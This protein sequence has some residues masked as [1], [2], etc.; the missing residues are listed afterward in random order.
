M[1][2][3]Y[4]ILTVL[5]FAIYP[6]V[7]A[8][9][10][11][12]LSHFPT[13]NELAKW[14]EIDFDF[15]PT[16][17]PVAPI[18]NIAEFERTEAVLVRYP[19]GIPLSLIKEM[20]SDCVV[21]TLVANTSQETTVRTQYQSEGI[22]LTN[23]Q[24]ILAASDSY[25]TRDYGP[26][27][28][29]DGNN[30]V[31]IV[32][33]TY[34]RPR[35]NDNEVPVFVADH[36]DVSYY[37]MDLSATGGNWMCDGFGNGVS[38]D[39]IWE[40]NPTM[41]HEDIDNIMQEYLGIDQFH[42]VDDPLGDYIK[43][44]DCWGK[45]LA[46]DKVLIGQVPETDSRYADFEAAADYFEN[47]LCP[48]GVPYRVYRVYT[49]GGNPAT[50][51][52]NSFIFNNKVFV[53]Q[54]GSEWDDEALVAYESAMPGYEIFGISF[55]SWEN[56]DA[57]HCR[58]HEIADREMLYLNHMPLLGDKP[59]EDEYEISI[60]ITSYGDHLII[61][62][63]VYTVYRINGAEWDTLVMMDSGDGIY[64]VSIPAGSEGSEIDYFIH[65]ADESGRSENCPFIGSY[66]PFVFF[67]GEQAN[68]HIAVNADPINIYCLTGGT[69]SYL[70][71]VENSGQLE[72]NYSVST[73][74]MI[75]VPY[76]YTLTDSP[77]QTAY[78]TNTYTE[79]GWTDVSVSEE[80][81][82]SHIDFTYSWNTDTYN[83]EGSFYCSS[84][85]GTQQTIASGQTDGTYTVVMNGFENEEMQGDWKVWIQDSYNDGGHQATDIEMTVVKAENP[86]EWLS[87]SPL[88]GTINPLESTDLEIIVDATAFSEGDY[89]GTITIQSNDPENSE[90]NIPI[91]LLV[92]DEVGLDEN[93]DI[94]VVC[95][96]IPAKD[97]INFSFT[98]Y[99]AQQVDLV[100]YNQ[101]G[102]VVVA[103]YSGFLQSGMQNVTFSV[104]NLPTGVYFYNLNSGSCT[105]SGRFVLSH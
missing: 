94:D 103:P 71:N 69:N 56:T 96:P 7:N 58:T 9:N 104:G 93:Q 53:P 35:P 34:N 40:E 73:N 57:L 80:G 55:G 2:V 8:Q 74:T 89:P 30:E 19:F 50:P 81:L 86:G 20:A 49:P 100:I 97:H 33:F 36:L 70:L 72:L 25:W 78:N 21:I 85:Q 77:A 47:T 6:A 44:I 66:D 87:V 4:W 13:A 43:H 17:A 48:Y 39:L 37:N 83:D 90:I 15:V 62:D 60:D 5:L 76:T 105:I 79:L 88:N 41:S 10:N 67:V 14:N 31:G 27:F 1:K 42:V 102:K 29:V 68:A 32:N 24:F 59:V 95:Y 52:S 51:Y 101:Y 46:P 28:I 54:S 82:V 23:C 26:W 75:E 18:R 22:N 92:R 64:S 63:S 38:T 98:L 61:S 84:P 11:Q 91:N 45:F 3:F 65:A 99:A 16:D 12:P